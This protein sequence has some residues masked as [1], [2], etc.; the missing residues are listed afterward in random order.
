MTVIFNCIYFMAIIDHKFTINLIAF[1]CCF[2]DDVSINHPDTYYSKFVSFYKMICV[3][4]IPSLNSI[5][6]LSMY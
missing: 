6:Y 5:L 2:D 3:V 1:A 4:R